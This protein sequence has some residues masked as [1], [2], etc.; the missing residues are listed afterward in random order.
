MDVVRQMYIQTIA[1]TLL[2]VTRLQ[3]FIVGSLRRRK[4]MSQSKDDHTADIGNARRDL[5]I[6][7]EEPP[8]LSFFLSLVCKSGRD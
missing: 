4:E 8:S 3:R 5:Q 2:F 6:S 1:A 7:L